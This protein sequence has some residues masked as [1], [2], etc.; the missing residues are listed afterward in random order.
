M[1]Y[2]I[3][4]MLRGKWAGVE[5]FLPDWWTGPTFVGPSSQGLLYLLQI[6]NM[7]PEN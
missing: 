6:T 1:F 7:L 4:R 2:F 5:E 3:S